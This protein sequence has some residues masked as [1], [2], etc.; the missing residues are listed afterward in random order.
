MT[1]FDFLP[2]GGSEFYD[3]S[4]FLLY[5]QLKTREYGDLCHEWKT[6]IDECGI[7]WIPDHH[8][9]ILVIPAKQYI[10][11]AAHASYGLYGINEEHF[12]R[13]DS[14]VITA[15]AVHER[16]H[17]HVASELRREFLAQHSDIDAFFHQRMIPDW[18]AGTQR[19]EKDDSYLQGKEWR[20]LY[21]PVWLGEHKVTLSGAHG[22]VNAYFTALRK[23][24]IGR[25]G[26]SLHAPQL[27]HYD[28]NGKDISL[29]DAYAENPRELIKKIVTGYEIMEALG[30]AYRQ[31]M[32]EEHNTN[33]WI[34]EEGFANYIGVSQA[35]L[36][37]QELQRYAH[38]D[39]E[40]VAAAQVFIDRGV[41][42]NDAVAAVHS[43]PTLAAFVLGRTIQ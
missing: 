37:V 13:G 12:A 11:G 2:D 21:D 29:E 26:N 24:Q 25:I 1:S 18:I 8:S 30:R 10:H 23:G 32:S 36:S 17:L 4:I 43:Y 3:D 38:Q 34:Q 20:Y 22:V 15:L 19:L 27:R 16:T 5:S 42:H 41:S 28:V 9:Q 7:G 39:N 31:R 14:S 35:G 40:K 6:R 33:L